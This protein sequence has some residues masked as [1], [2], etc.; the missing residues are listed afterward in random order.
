M[1]AHKEVGKTY[2]IEFATTIM[3]WHVAAFPKVSAICEQLTH[4]V[5]QAKSPLLE[6]PSLP[7]LRKHDVL[8]EKSGGGTYGNTFFACR[9]LVP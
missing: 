4:E 7:V 3:Y 5:L 8:G 9:D 2:V 6:D 1:L